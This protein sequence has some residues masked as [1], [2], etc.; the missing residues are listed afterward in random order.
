MNSSHQA[1]FLD[2]DGVINRPPP[3]GRYITSPGDFILLPGVVEAIC[4]LNHGGFRIFVVTNQRGIGRGLVSAQ[5]VEEIHARLQ[6]VVRDAGGLIERIYV[7]PHDNRDACACRKPKPG[8]LQQAAR[9]CS[10]HLA[11]CWM[12]GDKPSDM[13]AGRAARCR[14]VMVSGARDT[15]ADFWAA[16]LAEA[17]D[18]ILGETR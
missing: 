8:L 1:V 17:V 4:Q 12:V 16:N 2:R 15:T 13:A 11:R 9:E 10:L 7:C 14:T 3:E 18:Y 6:Q 5:I